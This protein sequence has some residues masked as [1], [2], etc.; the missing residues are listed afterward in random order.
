MRGVICGMVAPGRARE[1]ARLAWLDGQVSHTSN[2]IL[3]EVFNA[4]LAA[5]AFGG[6]DMRSLVETTVA[7]MPA[8]S[9]YGM[10]V[11]NALA[12]CKTSDDWQSAWA[13]CDADL[14]E[15][16]WIHAYPNAAAQIIALWFGGDDFDRTLAIIGGIGH[17]VDCNAA[18]I[19]CVLAIAQ[20]SASIGAKWR[21]PIGTQ[22]V[23]Y[24]RRPAEI[25]FAELVDQTV[26][27]TIRAVDQASR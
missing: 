14:I 17:D 18:Q 3:G 20:G 13:R 10:V 21:E 12:A 27:A 9:E 4:V 19:L 8:A 16:N 5:R 2:G 25:G 26:Q 23:T 11:R 22:I 6:G 7:L 15:Y 1:A 24:M